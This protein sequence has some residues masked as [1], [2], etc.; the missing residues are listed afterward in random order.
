MN[1]SQLL[2]FMEEGGLDKL[3]E[4]LNILPQAS[5]TLVEGIVKAYKDKIE[6]YPLDL[7]KNG[8]L[9]VYLGV[10]TS[11][12][13]DAPAKPH[14]VSAEVQADAPAKPAF[15]LSPSVVIETSI[16]EETTPSKPRKQSA[17]NRQN[18]RNRRLNPPMRVGAT[19]IKL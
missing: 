5:K 8:K 3:K 1:N 13:A 10:A 4:D 14:L 2:Q 19:P 18:K 15:E 9:K 11:V 16:P 6:G 7:S 12:S 17:Q